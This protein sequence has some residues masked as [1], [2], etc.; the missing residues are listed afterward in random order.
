MR[1]GNTLADYRISIIGLLHDCLTRAADSLEKSFGP[2]RARS[3]TGAAQG[4]VL[5]SKVAM[6]VAIAGVARMV[7]RAR[8]DGSYRRTPLFA[9]GKPIVTPT[10]CSRAQSAISAVAQFTLR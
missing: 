7:V 8:V 1:L 9:A 10:V 2:V 3:C 6:A 4:N 5:S